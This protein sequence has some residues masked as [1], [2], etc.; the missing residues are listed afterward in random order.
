MSLADSN[1]GTQTW[2]QGWSVGGGRQGGGAERQRV[3][4]LWLCHAT[5]PPTSAHVEVCY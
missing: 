2:L 3:L 4:L 1:K 5:G